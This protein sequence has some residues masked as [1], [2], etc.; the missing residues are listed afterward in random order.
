MAQTEAMFPDK[1]YQYLMDCKWISSKVS[2]ERR[3]QGSFSTWKEVLV[4][5]HA[6]QDKLLKEYNDGVLT[7]QKELRL[8]VKE[9]KG[10]VKPSPFDESY[11]YIKKIIRELEKWHDACSHG[12]ILNKRQALILL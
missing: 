1:S 7:N 5:N 2:Q 6:D 8:A 4:L 10:E 3:H 12:S 9:L 11:G